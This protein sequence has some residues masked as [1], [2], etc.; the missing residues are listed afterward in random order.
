MTS[1]TIFD[2][3][4]CFSSKTEI[5][6]TV[7]QLEALQYVSA[8]FPSPQRA[9]CRSQSQGQSHNK[10]LLTSIFNKKHNLSV[11]LTKCNECLN[12]AIKQFNIAFL[13]EQIV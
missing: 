8:V 6:L 12:S 5:L 13:Q 7:A 3:C 11:T 4:G 10:S 9:R 1:I 2:D